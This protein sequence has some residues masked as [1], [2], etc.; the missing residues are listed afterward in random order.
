MKIVEHSSPD[1]LA[2]EYAISDLN[3]VG[4]LPCCEIL[5]HLVNVSGAEAIFIPENN[6]RDAIIEDMLKRKSSSDPFDSE[7][8]SCT[9]FLGEKF[10][11]DRKHADAVSKYALEIFSSMKK[12]HGLKKRDRLLLRVASILHDV[13]QFLNNRQH[14][15]HSYYLIKNSQIPGLSSNELELVAVIARYHRRGLP[16]AS[17]VE[18]M[19]LEGEER[20]KVSKLAAILRVADALDRS[21][22]SKFGT[23]N[24]SFNSG[25]MIMAPDS[26]SMDISTESLALKSKSDLFIETYGIKP[27]F[28]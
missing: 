15:K 17:N 8:F 6:M 14:H 7:I 9:E 16:K 22:N 1:K 4:L 23:L 28:A 18:Y 19:Q 21:H 24:I 26:K 20:V 3:A 11:Y 27:E 10:N 5:S 2:S 13:G 12:I 25:R